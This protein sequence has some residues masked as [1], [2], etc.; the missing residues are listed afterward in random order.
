MTFA[1]GEIIIYLAVA[2][3]LGLTVGYLVWY[4]RIAGARTETN[5]M[6]S[7]L[8]E[9]SATLNLAEH[10][11]SAALN[12]RDH[13]RSQTDSLTTK[14]ERNANEVET[15]RGQ[16]SQLRPLADLV[17]ELRRRIAELN[18]NDPI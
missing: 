4:R 14:A 2:A 7:A 18:P 15:L 12:E 13:L 6:A 5:L 10:D 16:V 17:P 1:I 3:M 11:L 8:Q 9:R